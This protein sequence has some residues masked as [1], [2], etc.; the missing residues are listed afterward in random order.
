MAEGVGS[1]SGPRRRLPPLRPAPLSGSDLRRGHPGAGHA[2]SPLEE[3][4][5][6][7]PALPPVAL[8]GTACLQPGS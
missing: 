2:P 1:T 6:L 8:P 7:Q 5:G 3:G 4:P